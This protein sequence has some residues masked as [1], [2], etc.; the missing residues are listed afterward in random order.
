MKTDIILSPQALTITPNPN[1]NPNTN[2]NFNP[3]TNANPYLDP[4]PNPWNLI[5]E[6]AIGNIRLISPYLLVGISSTLT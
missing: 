2:P 1:L 5:M 6:M 4:N 3:K